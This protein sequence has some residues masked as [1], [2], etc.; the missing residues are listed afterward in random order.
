MKRLLIAVL[1]ATGLLLGSAI[2]ALAH[3]SLTKS[4]IEAGSEIAKI[5]DVLELEFAK[6][7]GL[8][9]VTLEGAHDTETS[10]KTAKSMSTTHSVTL[11]DLGPGSYT[12]TWRAVAGDGHV[13]TG[14]ISFTVVSG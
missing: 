10:L 1:A 3:T 8:A 9:S 11:P 6:A 7:V 14:E 2:P 5:P 4:N 12:L 13:M